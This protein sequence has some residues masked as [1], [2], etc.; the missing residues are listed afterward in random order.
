L[1]IVSDIAGIEQFVPDQHYG[2]C[3]GDAFMAGVGIGVFKDTTQV[4]EWVRYRSVVKPETSAQA[5]YEPYYQIYRQAYPAT[6]PL[7]HA[8]T[9]LS[10]K[11]QSP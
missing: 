4:S 9:R 1:Q 10:R 8:L 5:I 3:Y 2:A 7:M 11:G 6:V